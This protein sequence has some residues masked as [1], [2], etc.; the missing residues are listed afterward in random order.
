[1][2]DSIT[3]VEPAI[4]P[5]NRIV[6]LLDWELT[7][8]CNLDCEYCSTTG[9]IPGHDNSTKHPPL[10]ECL[11]T[12]DFMLAYANIYMSLRPRSL[13]Q[14]ILNVYGGES[15][16]HP[17]IITV[18]Q[19]VHERHKQYSD[20]WNLT[21]TTTTNAIVT[22][23]KIAKI[24]PLID[25]FTTSYHTQASP[26]QKQQFKKNLLTIKSS[27]KRLKCIVLMHPELELFKDAENMISWL[28]EHNIQYL[29]KPLDRETYQTKFNY[30]THQIKWF[31]NMYQDKL[32]N[33]ET[34]SFDLTQ[35][36]TAQGVDLSCRGRICCGGRQ[37]HQN[38]NY[39]SREFFVEN[40]FP[41]WY[42][43]VNHF[44]L[45]IKQYTG[46]IFVNKDCRMNFQGSVGSIGNLKQADLLL[47]ETQNYVDTGTMPIIQCKKSQC[48]C[49]LCAPKA[50]DLATYK[51]IMRK[52]EIPTSNL[53]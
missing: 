48:L 52:Y 39:K 28:E 1:M 47:A 42:C 12:I 21:I 46:N 4:D 20:K 8:K 29:S 7:L 26:K 5:N 31:K 24:I 9:D 15:L 37:L 38:Q 14:V 2:S 11:K 25:E 16:H 41:D 36:D 51:S 45:F 34:E 53:L 30:K 50:Q 6:F 10:D 49:G 44:F 23:K 17:D 43:S 32:F 3:V 40:R 22:D 27:G 35:E 33:S 13:R 19:Q 18:L